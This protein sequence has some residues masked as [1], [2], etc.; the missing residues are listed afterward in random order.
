MVTIN[1]L[2]IENVKRVRAVALSPAPSGLT[3]IGGRNGQG[4]TSVL[5]AIAWALGGEKFRPSTPDRDGSVLPPQIR[6]TLSNGVIVERKGK[7]SALKVTDPSGARSGQQLLDSLIE[8]LA[9]NLPKFMQA[10]DKDKAE[11]LLNIIGV[12]PQLKQ[13]D[14]EEA[15]LY[16][17]RTTLG[18]IADQ[19]R[20]YALEMVQ[21][22]D[23]PAD[24]VSPSELIRQQQDILAR[25]GENARLR[26][27]RDEIRQK[28]RYQQA[29]VDRLRHLL[30]DAE[31]EEGNYAVMLETAERDAIDLHDEST[32]A[33]EAAI[34][35]ID[36]TNRRV[37]ANLDREKAME[38]AKA[39]AD[40]YAI[41]SAQIDDVR[42]KRRAL[43]DGA[44]L[45]L[46][47]LSVEDGALRYNG[48]PWDCMSG[49]EQLRV[50]TAIVRRLNPECGFVL[51]DRLEAMDPQTLA[52][53]GAWLEAEGLQ[54]IAT[55]VSTGDECSIIIEDGMVEGAKSM[56]EPTP[57]F[58]AGEF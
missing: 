52:E 33:L 10:S 56:P 47:G 5:D 28:L 13:L 45:P 14:T 49:S 36:E 51:M 54:V 37:R 16:S 9:L 55:R 8:K 35:N 18:R 2:E 4:K 6:V 25:N 32:E 24:L 34:A 30:A 1:Q 3:V 38:D 57:T 17:E 46:P 40:Q 23:A 58:K 15:R 26:A 7:N 31:R 43:L 41:M 11:T 50:A 12:G 53:F 27:R 42:G 20:K 39:Y 29:E 21:Y 19:K 48:K 22:P 44:P